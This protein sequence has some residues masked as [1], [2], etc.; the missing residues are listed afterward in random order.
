M[1]DE[2][3]HVAFGRLALREYYPQLSEAERREREEFVIEGSHH[4]RDRLNSEEMW[5]R[6]GL[7]PLERGLLFHD[8]AETFLR[9]RRD[10]GELPVKDDEASRARLLQIAREKVDKM[11]K[12]SP[13]RHTPIWK[14]QWGAF[15]DLLTTFLRREAG[16]TR[17]GRPAYFEVAFGTRVPDTDEPH[18]TEPLDI[19][20]GD[21]RRLRVAGK[22]DRID[23]REDGTLVLRDYKSG[24][25]PGP[26]EDPG[27]FRGGRQLQIPFY[28]LAA[29]KLLP[30]RTVSF[31]FLDYV[32]QGRPVTFDLQEATGE[33]FRKLLLQLAQAMAGGRYVQEPSQCTWCD[34]T[35]VC[36]PQP[37]LALRRRFKLRDP[38]LQEYVRLRDYR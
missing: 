26:R 16:N 24:K 27:L 34:Y 17:L 6:I 2:A 37:L 12:G 28:V 25:A 23:V 22:I 7:D 1:Q 20:L 10:R 11:L 14:M 35:A 38:K 13:P 9:E 21:G 19:D 5:E 33:S 36:G 30:G 29:Q 18:S 3:R 15:E 31:A 32:D 4:L 8:V